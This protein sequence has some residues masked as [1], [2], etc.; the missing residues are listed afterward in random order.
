MKLAVVVGH[1]EKAPGAYAVAPIGRSEFDFNSDVAE[2]MALIDKDYGLEV[3]V[4]KRPAGVGY[5]TEIARAYAEVNAWR[6][7]VSVELHFNSYRYTSTGSETLTSGSK[8]SRALAEKVQAEM[9]KQLKL[10]DRGVKVRKSSDRGGRSLHAGKAPAILVEP[11]FGSNR[12]DC[13]AAARLGV[14][15][16]AKMYLEGVRAYSVNSKQ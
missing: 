15:G 9:L 6:A 7:D 8:K 10:H 1:N 16:F 14:T 13:E 12:S 3:K 4:F 2:T 5:S 11:F